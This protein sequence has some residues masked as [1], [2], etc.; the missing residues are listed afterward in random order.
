MVDGAELLVALPGQVD[1]SVRVARVEAGGDLGLLALG[2]VVHAV[3]EEPSDLVE[4]VVLV[5][6][7]AQGVL[8]DATP[9]LVDNRGAEPHHMESVKYCDRVG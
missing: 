7:V 6:A 3:A 9:D 8:L 5:T 2:G 1:F 4:R